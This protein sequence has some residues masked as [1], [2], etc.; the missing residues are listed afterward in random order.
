MISV[1]KCELGSCDDNIFSEK[2]RVTVRT[3][4]CPHFESEQA[5]DTIPLKRMRER[6]TCA[7]AWSIMSI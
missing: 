7:R 1:G 3:S 4:R 2:C 5:L 6:E